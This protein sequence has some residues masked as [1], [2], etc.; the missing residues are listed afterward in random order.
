M[1]RAIYGWPTATVSNLRPRS[2]TPSAFIRFLIIASTIFMANAVSAQVA[3]IRWQEARV[4]A[5]ELNGHGDA[6]RTR[7]SSAGR[8][9]IWWTYCVA[10]KGISYTAV[11]RMSPARAGMKVGNTIRV[12]VQKNRILVANPHG[13]ELVLRVTRQIRGS[14]CK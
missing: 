11:L 5:A 14:G 6:P 13:K 12:S 4:L 10:T 7:S 3:P 2:N 8:G 1:S 9:D